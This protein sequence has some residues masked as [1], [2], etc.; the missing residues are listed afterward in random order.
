MNQI[1]VLDF[2]T[3]GLS[4]AQGA[5]ATE[6]GIVLLENGQ[7]VDRYQSLMNAGVN[8]PSFITQ[9]TGIS[10]AMLRSAPSAETVMKEAA[11]FVGRASLVAHNAAFDRQFWQA[12]LR[13]IGLPGEHNFACTVL[14]SR[15]LFPH[16]PSH[17]LG[18][19]IDWHGLPRSGTAHRAMADAQ[20][21]A[22]L[23]LRMQRELQQRYQ[24]TNCQH[25]T[26]Q[27]LQR[28][29]I[30]KVPQLLKALASA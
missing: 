11:R 12:E 27:T 6:I 16:A 20:M 17:K 24:L 15:R 26:L 2:E 21:A 10:N 29:A 18:P 25:P 3:T 7:V 14:L 30:A 28:C 19:L 9:L 4:P 22:D 8:I 23:L 1:A 5:R 13:R